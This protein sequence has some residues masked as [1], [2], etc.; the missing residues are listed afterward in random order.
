M[1]EAEFEEELRKE[2]GFVIE[3]MAE[4]G[5]CLFRAVAHQVWA[6]PERHDLVREQT[7][8]WMARNREHFAQFVAGDFDAYIRHKRQLRVFGDHAEIHAMSE[9]YN[10]PVEVY[11]YDPAPLNTFQGRSTSSTNPP[12]RLSYH[13]QNHYNSI[14]DP[15]APNFCVGLGLPELSTP[16]EAEARL[17]RRAQEESELEDAEA[18]LYSAVVMDDVIQESE[19]NAV[20]DAQLQAALQASLVD[21]DVAPASPTVP[22]DAFLQ[23][24][25]E[26]SLAESAQAEDIA[27]REALQA[28]VLEFLDPFGD[29]DNDGLGGA[30]SSR[31][32]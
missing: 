24:A 5:N 15:A 3:R 2:R 21:M 12:I 22:D 17:V 8:D 11:A 28:S 27:L 6:D 32:T 9:I 20:D 18:Q 31:A 30:S 16:G 1:S 13:S 25:I 7:M 19:N 26:S 23:A 14:I 10:R 29:D 4:D